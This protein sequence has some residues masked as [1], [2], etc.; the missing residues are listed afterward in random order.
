M[1]KKEQFQTNF[2]M[3]MVIITVII[4]LVTILTAEDGT[5]MKIFMALG[6]LWFGFFL[7]IAYCEVEVEEDDF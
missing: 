7:G 2:T 6:A 3:V 4:G 5:A 1:T